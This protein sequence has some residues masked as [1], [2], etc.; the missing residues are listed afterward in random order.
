MSS[1]SDSKSWTQQVLQLGGDSQDAVDLGTASELRLVDE[2]WTV[3]VWVRVQTWQTGG[4]ATVL[5]VESEAED[6]DMV[7]GLADT[8]PVLE[9]VDAAGE[10]HVMHGE[11]SLALGTWYHL[12][13]GLATHGVL[14][15]NGKVDGRQTVAQ[16]LGR[17][18]RVRLGRRGG[19]LDFVG[20]LAELRIWDRLDAS[21]IRQR[22]RRRRS[23][24]LGWDRHLRGAWHL[25][26]VTDDGELADGRRRF[27]PRLE[28]EAHLIAPDHPPLLPRRALHFDGVDDK[29]VFEALQLPL[30]PD[31][32]GDDAGHVLT[33]WLRTERSHVG[34]LRLSATD[35]PGGFGGIEV[36]L[37]DGRPELRCS[38]NGVRHGAEVADGA[39]HLIWVR[40]TS[41]RLELDVDGGGDVVG[42]DVN[43]RVNLDRLDLGHAPGSPAPWFEGDMLA[44]RCGGAEVT[45]RHAWE[46][47]DA[48]GAWSLD[49]AAEGRL[50]NVGRGFAPFGGWIAEQNLSYRSPFRWGNR[51]PGVDSAAVILNRGYIGYTGFQAFDVPPGKDQEITVE[52]WFRRRAKGGAMFSY[53]TADQPDALVLKDSGELIVLGESSL[54][55]ADDPPWIPKPYWFHFALTWSSSTGEAKLYRNGTLIRTAVLASGQRLGRGGCFMLGSS[56]SSPGRPQARSAA[57]RVRGDYLYYRVWR[58]IL[59][60]AEIHPNS[61]ASRRADAF[62][63]R[64]RWAF[65]GYRTDGRGDGLPQLSAGRLDGDPTWTILEAGQGPLDSHDVQQLMAHDAY[66]AWGPLPP[67]ERYCCELWLRPQEVDADVSVASLGPVGQAPHVEFL[68]RP[69]DRGLRVVHRYR[70]DDGVHE[71]PGPILE[72]RRWHHVAVAHDGSQA[73]IYLRGRQA[74]KQSGPAPLPLHDCELLVGSRGSA[75]GSGNGAFRGHVC[76]LKLW[77]EAP[78]PGA[79]GRRMSRPAEVT[80]PALCLQLPF[81]PAAPRGPA[82]AG[83]AETGSRHTR[84]IQWR[85]PQH[86]SGALH[87]EDPRDGADL[88]RTA[89]PTPVAH[90]W[91]RVEFWL[92][93]EPLVAD[94]AVSETS[95]LRWGD[96]ETK[97]DAVELLLAHDGPDDD[98]LLFRGSGSDGQAGGKGLKI[99]CPRDGSFH[100]VTLSLQT[101]ADGQSAGVHLEVDGDSASGREA[102]GWPTWRGPQP[103]RLGGDET[104]GRLQALRATLADLRFWGGPRRGSGREYSAPS[105]HRYLHGIEPDLLGYWRLAG[106]GETGGRL[107]D[108]R[109]RLDGRVEG[110]VKTV[111]AATPFLASSSGAVQVAKVGSGSI[112]LPATG[113]DATGPFTF[114]S[115]V[116]G[117]FEHPVRIGGWRLEWKAHRVG[118]VWDPADGISSEDHGGAV[119]RDGTLWYHLAA[120]FDGQKIRLYV[121]GMQCAGYRPLELPNVQGASDR[122][123]VQ[124]MG[125]PGRNPQCFA[126]VR[127]W[128][129]ARSA[130]ALQHDMYERLGGAEAGLIACWPLDEPADLTEVRDLGPGKHHGRVRGDVGFVLDRQLPLRAFREDEHDPWER[131]GDLQR[132]LKDLDRR[133]V[134]ERQRQD[135]LRSEIGDLQSTFQGAQEHVADLRAQLETVETER[136]AARV[137]NRQA[138]ARIDAA[139]AERL[140][141]VP[142]AQVYRNVVQQMQGVRSGQDREGGFSLGPTSLELKYVL[143]DAGRCAQFPA[144][145][146]PVDAERLTR[147]RLQLEPRKSSGDAAEPRVQVPDVVGSTSVHARRLLSEA[148]LGQRNLGMALG[149]ER[150]PSMVGRVLRQVPQAGDLVSQGTVVRLFVGEKPSSAEMLP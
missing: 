108:D 20:S 124:L 73:F 59:P 117:D 106:D 71:H 56:Q 26:S 128:S 49:G 103:L 86:L 144:P 120:V 67:M 31:L 133:A 60:E 40:L 22:F 37:A 140:G 41:S 54:P 18:G 51:P 126:E 70:A 96:S 81:G 50:P 53:A 15:V 27:E 14:F 45:R 65:E 66:Q 111:E 35:R 57:Y 80:D 139:V 89:A 112:V 104:A 123:L 46:V 105:T 114:E 7:L 68:L 25:D 30:H 125:L 3:E 8:R 95:L 62:R 99:P 109:R 121:D 91:N 122:T 34:V 119:F 47:P 107:R 58:A 90:G 39:W 43:L 143:T 116:R 88:P 82:A 98:H 42:V 64:N 87:L 2:P 63:R 5:T 101:H 138:E 55:S 29:A 11:T 146:E 19:R 79:I 100:H 97:G 77:S 75:D 147:H 149:V 129:T 12:A 84:R 36:H 150:G 33:F 127:L 136:H 131:L 24:E 6:A 48:V 52:L 28:G 141:G 137:A 93:L 130:E 110:A 132:R 17:H 142:L 61:Q 113:L 72:P 148:K 74:D 83:L 92:R 102:P 94:A 4:R 85:T 118:L 135:E 9:W 32:Q 134:A 21:W 13:W 44:L 10:R 1:S 78:R 23:D 38:G 76:D 16:G 115:W 145:N 69:H